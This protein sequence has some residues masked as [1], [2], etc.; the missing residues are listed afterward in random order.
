MTG[1]HVQAR[2]NDNDLNQPRDPDAIQWLKYYR[3]E[4]RSDREII[5]EALIA[6][7][8]MVGNGW[9]PAWVVGAQ[10]VHSTTMTMLKTIL[11][12]LDNLDFSSVRSATGL[13]LT[14]DESANLAGAI[15]MLGMAFSI[16]DD[17]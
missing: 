7:G 12:K 9:M 4:G 6:L 8:V 17:E 13:P 2:L 14:H 3:N 15:S 1:Y 11:S 16:G 5:R 10:D